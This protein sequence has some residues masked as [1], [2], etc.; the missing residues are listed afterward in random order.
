MDT[1]EPPYEY[2]SVLYRY[3]ATI[4]GTQVEYH[5]RSSRSLDDENN[6]L[7]S[8]R[9][10]GLL[11][12]GTNGSPSINIPGQEEVCKVK[13]ALYQKAVVSSGR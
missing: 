11:I 5:S 1:C 4:C 9:T 6:A 8:A 2:R 10:S 3:P 12:P 7:E 13:V